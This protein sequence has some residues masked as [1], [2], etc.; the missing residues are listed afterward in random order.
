MSVVT[1]TT[2]FGTK[3]WFVGSM[4]GVMTSINPDARL[5]DLNHEVPPGDIHAGALSLLAS[6]RYFPAGTVHLV[7]V[8]PGVGGQRRPIAVRFEDMIFVGP[9]NGVLSWAAPGDLETRLIENKDWM[10]HP[11]SSTF[12][13]RDLFAPTAAYLAGGLP[14]ED[15][16][17]RVN[18]P[19]QL[20]WPEVEVSGRQL[21]GEVLHI[22]RFG[23]AITNIPVELLDELPERS[24]PRISCASRE[25][26]IGSHY[27]A[28]S[29]GSTICITASHGFLELATNQGNFVKE[30]DLRR[31][32]PVRLLW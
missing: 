8:D 27:G 21:E 5:V 30:T 11:V 9:D 13:G 14:F 19:V 17:R 1:L 20:P 31:G 26:V 12:H 10:L 15:V 25:V 16:G 23:N 4:K 32:D 28:V 24:S 3:D 29:P 18:N 2:D 7:V 6:A 22:D